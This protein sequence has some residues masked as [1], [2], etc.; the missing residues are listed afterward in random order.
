MICGLGNH[1]W[2]SSVGSRK[3][4]KYINI[5]FK[6]KKEE[7]T[8]DLLCLSKNVF[9]N[10]YA[11]GDDGII[12]QKREKLYILFYYLFIFSPEMHGIS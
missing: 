3:I 9:L 2:Y 11:E 4:N 12:F 1:K 6:K 8:T 5:A 7:E 10:Y